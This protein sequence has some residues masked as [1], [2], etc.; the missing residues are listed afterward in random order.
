MNTGLQDAHNLAFKLADVLRGT[1]R[2]GWLDR[3]EAER[4][5]VARKRL[6]PPPTGCSA[7]SPRRRLPI[8]CAAAARGPAD[9]PARGR[10]A[11]P[12]RRAAS[13]LFQ[14]VVADPHPL[15]PRPGREAGRRAPRDPV[16]GRRLPWTG[17]NYA[18]LRAACWQ[19]HGYG[20]VVAADAPDLGAAGAR[21]PGGARDRACEQ[22]L[23]Y[24]SGRTGSSPRAPT[25]RRRDGS[26]MPWAGE[27]RCPQVDRRAAAII[28]VRIRTCVRL[29]RLRRQPRQAARL[30]AS[31]AAGT[32]GHVTRSTGSPDD[33]HRRSVPRRTSATSTSP[34]GTTPLSHAPRPAR[35]WPGS[36]TRSVPAA[37][38]LPSPSPS[39]VRR[40]PHRRI[41]VRHAPM[42]A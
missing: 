20:G 6:S 39:A 42:A 10:R 40:R 28:P 41:R 14:Y 5:P 3:Y 22:G 24:L 21:L 11:A 36:P 25:G 23:F 18:V 26:G 12:A 29:P 30:S 16:I 31:C 13:R 9:R 35:S 2:D 15:P 27:F 17:G 1:R 37:S 33:R 34:G 19:I 4:R 7:R 8:R 32:A 38:A